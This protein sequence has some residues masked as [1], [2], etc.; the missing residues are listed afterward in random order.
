MGWMLWP[1]LGQDLGNWKG[2]WTGVAFVCFRVAKA[3]CCSGPRQPVPNSGSSTGQHHKMC[4]PVDVLQR[5]L[6]LRFFFPFVNSWPYKESHHTL[7]IVVS[8]C[9]LTQL[10]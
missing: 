9:K 7:R 10:Y 1:V 3:G 2:A 8:V 5:Q 6:N 4:K